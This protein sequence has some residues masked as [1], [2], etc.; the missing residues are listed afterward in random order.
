MSTAHLVV[1]EG[2]ADPHRPSGGN[3]YDRTVLAGLAERGWAVH[4]HEVDGSWPHPD[5]AARAAVARVLAG[6]PDGAP[7]LV[8]GLVGSGIPD[9]VV[10]EARRL[11]LAVL[12][13]LPLGHAADDGTGHDADRGKAWRPAEGAVLRAAAAVVTTS[14][15]TRTW[16][17]TTYGLAPAG[18]TVAP[19]GVVP[20]DRVVASASGSRLLCVGAVTPTKGHDL[21]VEALADVADL[22]WACRCIGSVEVEPA[23]AEQVRG[24]A[25]ALGLGE[26]LTFAGPRVGRDLDAGYAASD[27]V[28]VPSRVETYGMVVTEALARGIPVVG[29]DVGGL[30]EAL[31][32]APDRRRPGI[33]VRP[34]DPAALALAVR[35]WLT[36]AGLRESLR[37]A[38]DGRCRTLAGW[39]ETTDRLARVLL[40]VAA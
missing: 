12:V 29:A 24:R 2:V 3:T 30:P 33:L 9:V 34:D 40:G 26:R 35:H 10:P 5:P 23:F 11:R 17:V 32:R 39:S 28:L 27:L 21:L 14:H 4:Q 7:V 6:I 13:H 19:P 37:A 1:P 25:L 8:D 18:V 20:A 15:W 22:H 38:A 36:D 31:G 16:L